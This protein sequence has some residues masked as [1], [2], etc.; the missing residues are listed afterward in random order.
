L[1]VAEADKPVS[2]KLVAAELMVELTNVD[3]PPTDGAPPLTPV[4]LGAV[5]LNARTRIYPFVVAPEPGKVAP[6]HATVISV[7]DAPVAL[8][9]LACADAGLESVRKVILLP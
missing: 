5:G 9:P 7:P 1:Y 6:V 8:I 2:P 4:K 3:P